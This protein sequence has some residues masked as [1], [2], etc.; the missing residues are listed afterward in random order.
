MAAPYQEQILQTID[1]NKD[2]FA[3]ISSEIWSKPEPGFHETHAHELLASF[4][5]EEGF[6]VE[7][8]FVTSTGFKAAYS[9]A[10][11][12]G[13]GDVSP[14]VNV[15]FLCEYDAVAGVGHAAGHNLCTEAS[16]A[17]ALAV[18]ECI[19]KKIFKGKVW[20]RLYSV[21]D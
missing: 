10:D 16:V 15:C 3:N 13:S 19:Q 20:C 4:F 21:L 11:N 17:A 7:R 1:Q 8:H 5:A 18:K 2:R 9:S 6:Q 14:P 12:T